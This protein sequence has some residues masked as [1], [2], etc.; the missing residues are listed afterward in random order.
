[1]LG[2]ETAA[3]E[4]QLAEDRRQLLAARARRVR[5]RRDD[6]VLLGWNGLMVDALAR[7]GAAL[8]EP[9]YGDGRGPGRRLPP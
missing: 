7:A 2:Q 6:K 8:G 1:M 5:P 9:R 3:L 4:I